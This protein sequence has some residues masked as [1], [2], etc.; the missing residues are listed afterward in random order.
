MGKSMQ[1]LVGKVLNFDFP[2]TGRG[3][4]PKVSITSRH[5]RE[6]W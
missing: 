2:T 3:Q 1:T 5:M 6:L 4:K